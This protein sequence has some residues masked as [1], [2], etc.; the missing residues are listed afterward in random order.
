MGFSKGGTVRVRDLVRRVDVPVT[1][2]GDDALAV[3]LEGDGDSA[4]WRVLER[5]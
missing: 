1:T 4:L 2:L 3:D 5:R